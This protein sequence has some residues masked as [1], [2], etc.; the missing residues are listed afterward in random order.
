[1][2]AVKPAIQ[3]FFAVPIGH[4]SFPGA[5]A[6]C[7]TLTTLFLEREEEGERWRHQKRIDTMHGALYE[8]R[9]DLFSWPDPPVRLLTAGCH[10]CLAAFV[11]EV[12]DYREEDMERLRFDYHAWFHV[13]RKHGYQGLHNHPNA[14]WSGIF[15]VD[16]GDEP[17]DR[18]DS[19]LVRFHDPRSHADMYADAGNRNLRLP[20]TMGSLNWRHRRARIVLF[21][22]YLR[23]EIYPYLGERPRIVVAFNRWISRIGQKRPAGETAYD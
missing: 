19:G 12:N 14:S 4:G 20:W 1:M 10:G 22:S 3:P 9:F 15:C 13:T 8:S 6:L 16:P 11:R 23:H 2:D 21:P 5:E 7:D 17:R 18:P